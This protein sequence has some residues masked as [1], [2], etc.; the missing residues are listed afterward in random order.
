MW[1]VVSIPVFKLGFM[2]MVLLQWWTHPKFL[3]TYYYRDGEVKTAAWDRYLAIVPTKA[4]TFRCR[5]ESC[6]VIDSLTSFFDKYVVRLPWIPTAEIEP[7]LDVVIYFR[8]RRVLC[9]SLRAEPRNCGQG[10]LCPH[11]LECGMGHFKT[12][13]T[14]DL[15]ESKSNFFARLDCL[16]CPFP[17]IL[18][19]IT[20]PGRFKMAEDDKAGLIECMEVDEILTNKSWNVADLAG[21]VTGSM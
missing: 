3:L 21:K 11:R 2:A 18:K 13:E 16:F 17:N 7:D 12:M 20:P 5:S 8:I 19:L 1:C 9:R 14:H 4:G 6:F 15:F 10:Q